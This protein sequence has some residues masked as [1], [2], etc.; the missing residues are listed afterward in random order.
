M[1]NYGRLNNFSSEDILKKALSKIDYDG[2]S[3]KLKDVFIKKYGV[4]RITDIPG[5]RDKM[6]LGRRKY[7]DSLSD[8]EKNEKLKTFDEIRKKVKYRRVSNLEIRVQKILNELMYEYS[9]NTIICGYNFDICFK[10]KIIIE[11]NGDYWHANPN[12]YLMD[13]NII[14]PGGVIYKAS[15][16]WRKD[17]KKRNIVEN[18]G[19]KVI[20]LWESDLKKM[21]DLDIIN[22]IVKNVGI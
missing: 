7:W 17:E 21:K 4:E 15:D 19:Y 22:F 16:I 5:V 3:N 18:H 9:C 14:Y 8:G 10:N 12:K 1:K 20:Y 2:L 11:I 6:S 13:D